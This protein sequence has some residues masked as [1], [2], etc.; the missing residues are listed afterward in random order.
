MLTPTFEAQ[1]KAAG[2]SETDRSHRRNSG[3]RKIRFPAKGR[4]KSGGYRTVHFYGGDD[5]PV[6]LLALISKGQRSDLSERAE[7][8]PHHSRHVGRCLSGWRRREGQTP[9]ET[10]M[11][12]F[13]AD[14]IRSAKEAV[15]V[16]RGKAAPARVYVP[17]SID[18]RS[19][20]RR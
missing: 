8:T 16:A 19:L 13:G 14:L 2:V 7:R 5:V 18:I 17:S 20:R 1:A 6:F 11:S 9:S 4:G 10:M 12:K 3:A 15:A